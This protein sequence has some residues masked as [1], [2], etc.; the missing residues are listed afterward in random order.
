M[1]LISPQE[2]F[3]QLADIQAFIKKQEG[4]RAQLLDQLAAMDSIGELDDYQTENGYVINDIRIT[5]C[6]RTIWEYPDSLKRKIKA[7]QKDAQ[8][9]GI[10]TQTTSSYYRVTTL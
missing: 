10:A 7:L 2:L 6:T 8:I 5:S 9:D 4:I 3:Q 1:S